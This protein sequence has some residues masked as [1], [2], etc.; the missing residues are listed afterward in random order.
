MKDAV[1]DAIKNGPLKQSRKEVLMKYKNCPNREYVNELFAELDKCNYFNDEWV[2]R[3]KPYNNLNWRRNIIGISK[4]INMLDLGHDHNLLIVD[5]GAG[6]GKISLAIAEYTDQE[7][8][9]IEIYAIDQSYAMLAKCPEHK[10]IKKYVADIEYMTFIPDNSVDRIICSMVLHSEYKHVDDVMR[11]LWRILK[12]GGI[13][14]IFESIPMI[15]D[16]DSN[17]DGDNLFMN[18]Y[19]SFLTMKEDRIMFTKGGLVELLGNSGFGDIVVE[20]IVLEQQSIKN[21]LYNSCTEDSLMDEIMDI[22][23]NASEIVKKGINLV[24]RCNSDDND[25]DIF[26]DW[27]FAVVKGI[28]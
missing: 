27:K 18:F 11:E 1:F 13:L 24:E 9:D 16:S 19:N 22:H 15:D 12:K 28:K 17:S 7:N 25:T 6:T 14:V 2:G 8:I 20:E 5:A 23:R 3:S 4:T 21:W 10:K 26:C